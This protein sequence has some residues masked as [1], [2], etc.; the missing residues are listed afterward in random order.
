[1]VTLNQLKNHYELQKSIKKMEQNKMKH[2]TWQIGKDPNKNFMAHL[3]FT[4]IHNG[5]KQKHYL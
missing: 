2:K 1:M 5:N 4:L 3:R